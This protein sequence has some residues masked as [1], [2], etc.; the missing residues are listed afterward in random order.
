M[1]D[2]K[3]NMTRPEFLKKFLTNSDEHEITEEDLERVVPGYSQL[4]YACYT[5]IIES[6]LD[7]SS[8][9]YVNCDGESV[10]L[11][12]GSKSQAKLIKEN[13]HKEIIRLGSIYYKI[14]VKVDG[15]HVF[16]SI[17]P[18]DPVD[19]EIE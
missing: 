7:R 3:L 14:K 5:R 17:E 8:I 19:E 10:V 6:D 1:K 9:K 12:L 16:V 15:V 13:C 4:I 11:K 2:Y 18:N